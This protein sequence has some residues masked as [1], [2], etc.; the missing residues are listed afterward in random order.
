M[1]GEPLFHPPRSLPGPASIPP[2]GSGRGATWPGTNGE[3]RGQ[4][5]EVP[6][7]SATRGNGAKDRL[8]RVCSPRSRLGPH[9]L[10]RRDSQVPPDVVDHSGVEAVYAADHAPGRVNVD[11]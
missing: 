10:D 1:T 7:Y 4:A 3:A 2:V 6:S 8:F 5:A 9:S 11:G